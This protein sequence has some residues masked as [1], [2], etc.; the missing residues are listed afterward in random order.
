[1]EVRTGIGLALVILGLIVLYVGLANV[2]MA[3]TTDT[4]GCNEKLTFGPQIADNGGVVYSKGPCTQYKYEW[5]TYIASLTFG[6]LFLGLG[7]HRI[8][9]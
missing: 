7:G 6:F 8:Y 2:R 4:R 3:F 9:T 1:M 5:Q